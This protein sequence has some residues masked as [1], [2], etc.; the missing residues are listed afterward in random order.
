MKNIS[1][2]YEILQYGFFDTSVK[3]PEKTVTP[4]RRLTCFEIELFTADQPGS[5]FI[6]G[7]EYPLT[8]G[9]LICGKPGHLRHS[10]LNFKCCYLHLVSK[11]EA[12]DK[13]LFSLPDVKTVTCAE[14]IREVF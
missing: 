8:A 13:I 10:R 11:S 6:N 14:T 7:K 12:L 1:I 9:T 2:C 5:A 3:F 4:D